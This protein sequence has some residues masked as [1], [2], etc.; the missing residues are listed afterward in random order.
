[1][2]SGGERTYRS[3]VEDFLSWS[4]HLVVANGICVRLRVEGAL[5]LQVLG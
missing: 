4:Q 5:G 3:A 2:H 1:M